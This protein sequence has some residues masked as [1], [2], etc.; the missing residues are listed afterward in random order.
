MSLKDF[1][2]TFLFGVENVEIHNRMYSRIP[3]FTGKAEEIPEHLYDFSV[4]QLI[5]GENCCLLIFLN[6]EEE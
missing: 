4:F 6:K 2:D 1:V 3:I 5:P